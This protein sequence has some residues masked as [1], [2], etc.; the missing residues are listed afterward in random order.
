MPI[1]KKV[2]C[3]RENLYYHSS[4]PNCALQCSNQMILSFFFAYLFY[5]K[6]AVSS[7][8]DNLVDTALKGGY[9][10]SIVSVKKA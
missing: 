5:Y 2:I 8:R 4:I 1:G 3:K 6:D 9:G 7:N 10:I